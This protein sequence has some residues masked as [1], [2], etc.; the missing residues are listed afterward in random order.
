MNTR[1][2]PQRRQCQLEKHEMLRSAQ[3][4]VALVGH[5]GGGAV[6]ARMHARTIDVNGP[7]LIMLTDPGAVTRLIEQA[8]TATATVGS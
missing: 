7:H 6:T 1:R 8:A 3:P 5:S 2:I 4:T